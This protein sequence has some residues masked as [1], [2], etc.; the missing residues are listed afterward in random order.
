MVNIGACK[1]LG[2]I[3][4]SLFDCS[5]LIFYTY[6]YSTIDDGLKFHPTSIIFAIFIVFAWLNMYFSFK[7]VYLS[8]KYY[9]EVIDDDIWN[10][11]TM[12]SKWYQLFSLILFALS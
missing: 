6:A 2:Y 11:L 3:L 10:L 12:K 7:P 4:S 8:I 9:G 1:I 5:F